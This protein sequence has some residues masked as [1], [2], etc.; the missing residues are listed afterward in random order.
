MTR[1]LR[2]L[3]VLAATSLVISACGAARPPAA[4]VGGERV[5]D[6]ELAH[7]VQLFRFITGVSRAPCGTALPGERQE[8]ACARLTLTN[9]IQELIAARYADANGVVVA[10]AAVA[11]AIAQLEENLGGAD[12]LDAEL[13]GYGLTRADLVAL[14]RRILLLN[15]VRDAVVAELLTD[16][17]LLELYERR[18]GDF[19]QIHAKHILVPTEAEAERILGEATAENF[20]DL[21][22]EFSNDPGSAAGGGDLGT[23]PV[24]ALDAQFVE[25]AR[26]L[27]PG[28]IGGPFQTPFGWHVIELVS[29]DV[30]PFEEARGQLLSEESGPAFRDWLLEQLASLQIEVNPKYGALDASTG[31]VVPVRSTSP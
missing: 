11:D 19:T 14:A 7:D 2:L 1:R 16:E 20:G 24:S 9:V 25:A 13:A 4:V 3:A 8:S 15:E 27:A 6:A 12:P 23:L 5:T 26:S 28:Q 29:I 21:A 10:D 18:E 30:T 31:E 17:R 22:K